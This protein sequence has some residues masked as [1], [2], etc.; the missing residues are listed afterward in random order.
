LVGIGVI[1]IWTQ[2]QPPPGDDSRAAL[3]NGLSRLVCLLATAAILFV[4][5]GQKTA[6]WFRLAPAAL[7]LVAWLDV[8]THEPRQNP[9]VPPSVYELNLARV[10]LAMQPQPELGGSRAM[11]SPAAVLGLTR[12]AVSDPKNNFL[13]K[14]AGYC[15]DVN[16]LDNVPKVDG[17]FSLTPR[18]FDGLLSLIYSATNGEWSGLEDFL[19]VSQYTATNDFMAWQPRPGFRPLVTAGQRPVF[20]DDTHTAWTFGRNEFNPAAT[21]FLPPEARALVTVS[22]PAAATIIHP[23]F[24]TRTVDFEAR[25]D[26]PALAVVAQTYYPDWHAEIDGRPARLLRANVAFQAV[27]IPAGDHRVH[28]YYE[29]RAFELGAAL[30]LCMWVNCFVAWLALRRRDLAV[31][32]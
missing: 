21:V 13:A 17:F 5:T 27:Q 2:C 14:R 32:S 15:A 11:L 8:W 24:T 25:A 19:G 7:I 29:D 30:S 23:E 12:L 22:N 26:A 31:P 3:L 1:V 16:L 6:P 4:L 10:K 18:E 28:L 20:L 9:T